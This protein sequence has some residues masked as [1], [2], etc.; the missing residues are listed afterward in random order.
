MPDC[1]VV[2]L[3]G[4]SLLSFFHLVD[5]RARL[6]EDFLGQP[7]MT[8]IGVEVEGSTRDLATLLLLTRSPTSPN[9]LNQLVSNGVYPQRQKI[10]VAKGTTAPRGHSGFARPLLHAKSG[11]REPSAEWFLASHAGLK[12]CATSDRPVRLKPDATSIAAS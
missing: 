5:E 9:R 10:L 12:P 2:V 11:P 7:H 1:I 3:N 8:A 4:A 6:A